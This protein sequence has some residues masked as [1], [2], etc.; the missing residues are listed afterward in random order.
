MKSLIFL[1]DSGVAFG[2]SATAAAQIERDAQNAALTSIRQVFGSFTVD[3]R[4]AAVDLLIQQSRSSLGVETSNISRSIL[5]LAATDDFPL[6]ARADAT[7]VVV[8]ESAARTPNIIG[9]DTA[10]G[11]WHLALHSGRPEALKLGKQVLGNKAAMGED[12]FFDDVVRNA[13]R[14][15]SM[16]SKSVVD[17]LLFRLFGDDPSSI[18]NVIASAQAAN[19][20]AILAAALPAIA[21]RIKASIKAQAKATT[22]A[23]SPATPP[24]AAV[25]VSTA[26]VEDELFDP[27]SLIQ[28][29]AK[30]AGTLA[31]T[32]KVAAQILLRTLLEVDEQQARDVV[33]STIGSLS[34]VEDSALTAAVLKA[35]ARRGVSNWATWLSVLTSDQVASLDDARKLLFGLVDALWRFSMDESDPVASAKPAVAAL[36]PLLD[37]LK[38]DLLTALRKHS[39]QLGA[40]VTEQSEI[41]PHN[42]RL[43]IATSFAASGLASPEEMDSDESVLI[44]STLEASIP[45]ELTESPMAEYV[46]GGL[47]RSLR[48][49][50][51]APTRAKIAA[52]VA[53]CSWL[54]EFDLARATVVARTLSSVPHKNLTIPVAST[55]A[56]Y[57][58]DLSPAGFDQLLGYWLQTT[59]EPFNTVLD[60]VKPQ[61]LDSPGDET[62][63]GAA[64]WQDRI[65]SKEKETL[66]A[67]FVGVAGT[68]IPGANILR[69]IGLQALP[70]THLAWLL[71][72]RFRSEKSN[73][74][75]E[76]VLEIWALA[77]PSTEE[78][79]RRLVRDVLIPMLSLNTQAAR[80]AL[81]HAVQLATPIP[82]GLRK[83]LGD[84]IVSA[85]KGQGTLDAKGRQIL[86]SLGYKTESRGLFGLT[87]VVK[88][89]D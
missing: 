74:G 80:I 59:Q 34:P 28:E 78:A 88:T 77:S 66:V 10:V 68:A 19:T 37:D 71:T 63:V 52:S 15:I 72:E 5:A 24:P 49:S 79:R 67:D 40:A 55:I 4:T 62:L 44:C 50:I 53:A 45:A 85:T 83:H 64:S 35:T 73:P 82:G 33:Q 32:N 58:A 6:A 42:V 31:T 61:L 39:I 36:I 22:V 76:Q 12:A 70:E 8:A 87:K 20:D 21:R 9:T 26:Q 3:Q 43:A 23:S 16:D 17:G 51:E 54:S 13:A 56:S 60:L 46:I 41:E 65:S 30:F 47:I 75:R 27:S 69:A 57:R 48:S 81:T 38:P 25:Q 2:L 86:T 7:S 1:Q 11:A 84:S 14:A 29:L 18:L 89:D